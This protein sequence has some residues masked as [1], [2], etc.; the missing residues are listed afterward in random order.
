MEDCG[1]QLKRTYCPGRG[2]PR[3]KDKHLITKYP[4]IYLPKT[5]LWSNLLKC[6]YI[7]F[8]LFWSHEFGQ[9]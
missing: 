8:D 6:V 2:P 4:R 7:L 3:K 9:T 1:K 5:Q